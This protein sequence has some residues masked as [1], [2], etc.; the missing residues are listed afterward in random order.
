VT[1]PFRLDGR[2]AL[3]TGAGSVR[4]I[5]REVARALAMAGA[6]VALADLDADGAARNAAELGGAAIGLGVDVT[7]PASVAGAVARA[8]DELGPVEVLVCSAGITRGTALW[9]V[10]LMEFDRVM[11]VNVRGGFICLQAVL[12]DM[13]ARGWGRVIL[14]GSQ[15]GKQGG[16]VFGS[17]HYACSKAALRGLCQGAARELGPFGITCNVISPGMVDTEIVVTGG[18]TPEQRDRLAEQVSAAAP[19]RRIARPSDV[20]AAA[21]YLASEEAGYVTG[22]VLDVNGGA[23]FD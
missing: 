13:R 2:T 9:D 17:T 19:M 10:T 22:E 4:G 20:A 15:A 16:G 5:G 18:A 11:A 21:L 6:R 1:E 12:P 8:R 7:D 23:Y 3:V 14:L